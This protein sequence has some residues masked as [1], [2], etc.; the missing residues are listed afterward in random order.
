VHASAL[1]VEARLRSGLSRRELARRAGTSAATLA[2][3]EAGRITPSVD[4]LDRLIDAAGFDATVAL[5]ARCSGLHRG[6]E[7]AEVLH[8]AEQFPARHASDIA[9]PA[10]PGRSR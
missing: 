5:T 9:V 8:L 2:A 7:L 10:F 3:Y 6:E 4:T 1:V